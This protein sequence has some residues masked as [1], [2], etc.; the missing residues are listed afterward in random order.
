MRVINYAD[1]E[2]VFDIVALGDNGKGSVTV[3]DRLSGQEVKHP[4]P[5]ASADSAP[6]L[7]TTRRWMDLAF[8]LSLMAASSSESPNCVCCVVRTWGSSWVR[9]RPGE[10]H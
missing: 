10:A 2:H 7:K 6:S 3:I 5:S 1:T 8:V 4:L 9:G